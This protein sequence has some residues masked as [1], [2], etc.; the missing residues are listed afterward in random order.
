MWRPRLRIPIG[1]QL[2][3]V[4]LLFAASLATLAFTALAAL[5]REGRR[6]SAERSLARAGEELARAARTLLVEV[7]LWPAMSVVDWDDLNRR[8]TARATSVLARYAGVE[9]GY[10]AWP[11]R[12]FVGAAFPTET[13][14]GAA[15]SMSQ[16]PSGPPPREF[17]RIEAQVEASIRQ[18]R[19]IFVVETI[20]PSVVAIRTAP[21]AT[22]GRIVGATWT[23]TR[24]VDP[25]A[26]HQS[27]RGYSLAAGL[28]LGGIAL[29][30]ILTV[31]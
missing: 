14:R 9:G 13:A 6:A 11:E 26:L 8:L 28:A 15:T 25:I 16:R 31:G 30:L 29:A 10:W 3:A 18:G 7:R 19:A 5:G 23:M 17:D 4:C 24:L 1:M 12:R 21:I 22:S 2:G 27:V 20:P